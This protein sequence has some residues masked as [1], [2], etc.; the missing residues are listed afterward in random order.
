MFAILKN[1]NFTLLWFAGLTSL[2][3][4]WMLIAAL[5][6][7]V[8]EV[9]G[10]ALAT[11][12]WLI[13]SILP[14]VLLGP[15]AGVFVDRWDRRRTMLVVSLVQ[16][17]VIPLLFLARSPELIWIVYVV[18][19][20]EA[21]LANFFSPAENAL[22]PTLVGED[23]L[24]AAN[25]MNS[26][27]D[28]LARIIGPAVGGVL[29]GFLGLNSVVIV[30]A[31]SYL[32]AALLIASVV[33]EK[34]AQVE[35]PKPAGSQLSSRADQ[36][37]QE[38]KM[39]LNV[40]RESPLLTGTFL[41]AG[42]A[43]FGDSILSAITV[44]FAQD[45]MGLDADGFGIILTARGIGGLLGGLL[46]AQMG[47]RFSKTQLVSGGLVL[48]GIAIGLM[49]I[50]PTLPVVVGLMVLAGPALIGW[51]VSLQ[52]ILQQATADAFRGRV[53]GAF[54]T[55]SALLMVVGAFI[56]G[57]LTDLIGSVALITVTALLYGVAGVIAAIR[58]A[59]PIRKL[60]AE[61]AAASS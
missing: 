28:N 40:I 30:D 56:S 7:Y 23:Q 5:P 10:S 17:A 45:V 32:V 47:Q 4:T 52:T 18:G 1:R 16:A 13:A 31:A 49:I 43:L 53:F 54:G 15:I 33:V 8:Y 35:E 21:A 42:V 19:F 36:V 39:G 9:T 14:G 44:V 6:F 37:W 26:L 25:S 12:G 38:F 11:S 61:L 57:A 59:K 50:F 29:L 55:I 46:V 48:S 58:L 60:D 27:N 22:L 24:I 3:G 34:R 51:I 41:V 20:I 2:I